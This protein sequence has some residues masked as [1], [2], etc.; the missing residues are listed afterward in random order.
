M[1]GVINESNEWTVIIH[2]RGH[3][4]HGA[5]YKYGSANS[6]TV[7][8]NV[9]SSLM[10]VHEVQKKEVTYLNDER[11]PCQSKPRSEEISTCIQHY[12]ENTMRC[13]LPWHSNQSK[14]LPQCKKLDQYEDFLNNY[15][16]I[17]NQKEASI[18]KVTGCLPSCKRN[19]FDVKVVNRIKMPSEDGKLYYSALFY[20]PS[21]SYTEKS[22]YYTYEF[23]DYLADIGGYMG[24][25]LGY[26]LI[27]FYDGFKYI[28]KKI[29][30]CF[31]R[32]IRETHIVT[33]DSLS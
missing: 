17:S 33:Q 32:K 29:M 18:A 10:T 8:H 22:Y 21:G 6:Y 28:L 19:E 3:Y 4:I 27:S 31:Q 15:L 23:S 26:S 12:I 16:W 20:Y 13:R 7:H 25:L 14:T 9:K 30:T 11:T 2:D 1:Y 5:L 24:L